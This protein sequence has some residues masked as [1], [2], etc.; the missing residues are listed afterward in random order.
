M[1]RGAVIG[2]AAAFAG[3]AWE[4]GGAF[5]ELTAELDAAWQVDP[6]RDAGDGWL[7]LASDYQVRIDVAAWTTSHLA[8]IATGGP[9]SL[10]PAPAAVLLLATGALDL[11]AG[12]R[13]ELSCGGTPCDLPAA[14]IER[15]E[16]EVTGLSL[17]GT[18]RDG[19]TPPRRAEAA[20]AA[21]AMLS[22]R[23]FPTGRIELPVDRA[24]APRIR[25]AVGVYPGAEL[26]DDVDW[27]ALGP[28][29]IDLAA[30]P[31]ALDAIAREIGA[32][33]LALDADRG[34]EGDRATRTLLYVAG[35]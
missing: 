29:P 15:V 6:D 5:G 34:D 21:T 10:D 1:I 12:Q 11:I 28:S 26:L 17:A 25:L 30:A 8:V 23:V 9:A 13:I 31:A 22:P 3:C 27:G 35:R 14:T 20:F 2:A 32:V 33:E 18:V 4:P 7:R 24:S 19:R 16:L